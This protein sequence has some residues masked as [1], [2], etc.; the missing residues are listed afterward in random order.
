MINELTAAIEITEYQTSCNGFENHYKHWLNRAT[1]SDGV[2]FVAEKAGAYWL[3]DAITSHQPKA[4]PACQG[5]QHWTLTKNKTGSGAKLVCTDGGIGGAKAKVVV[6]Q[7]IPFTDFPL[8]SIE[9]YLENG[10]LMLSDER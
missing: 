3:I 9:M 6:K 8:P 1:Y 5:F 10:V 7:S 2:K 4:A